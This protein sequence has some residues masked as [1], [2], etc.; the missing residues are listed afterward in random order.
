M[1]SALHESGRAPV[2]ACLAGGGEMGALLRSFDWRH[3]QLGPVEHWPQSLLTTLGILLQ[4]SV[5][6]CLLWGRDLSLFYN[7]AYRP[8]LGPAHPAL[9]KSAQA[10]LGQQWQ[11]THPL[12]EPVLRGQA[13]R[14]DDSPVIV[15]RYGYDE[16]AYFSLTYSPIRD[17]SGGV[18]G[19]LVTAVDSTE[20]VLSARRL[21][22]LLALAAAAR[23]GRDA[24]QSVLEPMRSNPADLPFA[25]LYELE[26]SGG[27]ALRVAQT[28]SAAEAVPLPVE[29]DLDEPLG[30]LFREALNRGEHLLETLPAR[31]PTASS[32]TAPA[33]AA[34]KA[35]ILRIGA[36]DERPHGFLVLG[37]H[38]LRPFDASYVEFCRLVAALVNTGLCN[39]VA[40]ERAA[41]R[42]RAELYE[43]LMQAPAPVCV[44]HG[45]ELIVEAANDLYHHIC[46]H[47]ALIGKSL[48]QEFPEFAERGMG[49]LVQGVMDRGGTYVE[50]EVPLRLRCAS[51]A[52]MDDTYW[53]FIYARLHSNDDALD[54]VVVF[55][56][57]VTDLVHSRQAAEDANLRLELAIHAT[58][59]GTWSWD[60]VSQSVEGSSRT[61]TLFARGGVAP[62][63][64]EQMLSSI[65]LEDRT[66]VAT[67]LG[68]LAASTDGSCTLEFRLAINEGPEVWV[69]C[70]ARRLPDRVVGTASDISEHKRAEE[71]AAVRAALGRKNEAERAQLLRREQE[72]RREAEAA[73]QAKD[74]FLALLG[75][76][77]RNPLAPITTALHLMKAK[78][79]TAIDRERD[80]IERQ[81]H[82]M[83]QLVDDLLDVARVAQGKI[84]LRLEVL[85]LSTALTRAIET[86]SPLLEQRAH[87]LTLEV[88]RTG[89][90]LRGDPFRLAQVFANLL[91]NAAKY[92]PP[93]GEITV[94]AR[95]DGT[96]VVVAVADN[97]QGIENHMLSRV[98]Q[99]FVQGSRPVQSVSG[100][101]GL[102][103]PLVRS[104]L[105]LHEGTVSVQSRGRG[106][107]STFIVNLPACEVS[108]GE[109]TPRLDEVLVAESELRRILI[110]DD[111]RDAAETLAEALLTLGFEARTALDGPAALEVAASFRPDI[112]VLDIGLPVMDGHELARKLRVL[113]GRAVVLVALTG[114]GQ[115]RD[116]ARSRSAGFDE[117]L[118]KPV[119]IQALLRVARTHSASVRAAADSA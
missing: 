12:L 9:G 16:E 2:D 64:Y 44:V 88:P 119:E 32:A 81:V 87:R 113:L 47:P 40:R 53:N 27:K 101:L 93:G 85:E 41:E 59:L 114:Y 65:A 67:Q 17:E 94:T 96:R 28:P 118:V 82:H 78:K 57:E 46:G 4:S 77:L 15:N 51:A 58:G 111:N 10:A 72:A 43:I 69:R 104:L 92:T 68:R 22:T 34:Q 102:G 66:A 31:L 62:T 112:A 33:D 103:L 116:R 60:P 1:S 70:A 80:V 71:E 3:S 48:M 20:R 83:V 36:A 89:L 35:F 23:P 30:S 74:E 38:S 18:G 52:P 86:A 39:A 109:Q 105:N 115:D 11:H 56:N 79:I 99:P 29:V 55:A 84:Q 108:V 106:L 91:T 98:F 24:R 97:G 63:N 107:G 45:R 14:L 54:R 42:R 117:H 5:G 76:E 8:I 90:P 49:E 13:Q 100:G 26:P 21:H 61:C 50:R 6:M 25:L 95:R 7:D 110:V 73:N 75:H 37:I 19:V